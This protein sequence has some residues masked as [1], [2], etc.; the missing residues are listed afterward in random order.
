MIKPWKSCHCVSNTSPCNSLS[1]IV[2]LIA[3]S[4]LSVSFAGYLQ[5]T[6]CAYFVCVVLFKFRFFTG[7][8]FTKDRRLM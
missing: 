6:V 4:N 5:F 1:H 7:F 8:K 3:K 2:N